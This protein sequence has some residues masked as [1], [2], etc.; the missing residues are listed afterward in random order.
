LTAALLTGFASSLSVQARSGLSDAQAVFFTA[1]ALERALAARSSRRV[2]DA[3]LFGAAAG[4]AF[5][6]KLHTAFALAPAAL[7]LA[8][9][10]APWKARGRLLLVA[11]AASLPFLLAFLAANYGRWGDPLT[12]GYEKSTAQAW[13]RIPLLTGLAAILFSPSKGV[14][15]YALP[16]LTFAVGGAVRGLRGGRERQVL[17]AALVLSTAGALAMPASTIEWHGSWAFGPRYALLAYPAL[18]VLTALAVDGLRG[19]ARFAAPVLGLAGFALILPG[20][21]TSPFAAIAVSM[22]GARVQWT[23]G[24]PSFPPH[25]TEGD[26][27]AERFQRLCLTAGPLNFL[28]V[29]HALARA[30][31]T[32]RD[33]LSLRGDLGI[34]KDGVA[35]PPAQ[36]E[37]LGFGGI[38]WVG[39]LE[40]IGRKG[41]LVYPALLLLTGAA[42]AAFLVKRARGQG[43][44]P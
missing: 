24:D 11:G 17:T 9:A 30:A 6:T 39:F 5:L 44:S 23:S 22:E 14:V 35:R 26:R 15:V 19:R 16:I 1:W 12:T 20:L 40:R 13:F 10:A 42:A 33:E 36:P 7:L 27:D 4:V 3:V 8:T 34:D 43:C 38:G 41:V 21:L 25:Y 31:L 29:Q 18:G 37:Y 2:L 32:G 28:R